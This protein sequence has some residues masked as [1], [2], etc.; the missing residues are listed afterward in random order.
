[1]AAKYRLR[2]SARFACAIRA[3]SELA[4]NCPEVARLTKLQSIDDT[5]L[6]TPVTAPTIGRMAVATTWHCSRV[7][8]CAFPVAGQMIRIANTAART[9]G[10]S[11]QR[12]ANNDSGRCGPPGLYRGMAAQDWQQISGSRGRG[13]HSAAL[14]ILRHSKLR[15]SSRR[16]VAIGIDGR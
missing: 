13:R 11:T 15:A 16:P 3:A 6:S 7:G 10:I 5:F 8:C 4:L 2:A 1:M 14:R 9:N 12:V